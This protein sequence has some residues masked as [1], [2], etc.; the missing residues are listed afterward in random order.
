MSVIAQQPRNPAP[1]GPG[2]PRAA[3]AAPGVQRVRLRVQ[4]TVQGVGFRPF[5]HTLAGACGLGG[6]VYNDAEGVRIELEGAPVALAAFQTRLRAEL[7]PLARIEALHGEEMAPLGERAFRIEASRGALQRFTLIS[8]DVATCPTCLEELRTAGNRR[9]RHPF[10]NC[11]HCGPRFTLIRDIPYDRVNTTMAAFPLCPDCEGEYRDPADRRFHAEPTACPHCGPQLRLLDAAGRALAG[12]PLAGAV[13]RLRAGGIVAVKGIGGFHLAC[14]ARDAAAVAELRR[15]KQRDDKPFAVMVADLA[16]ARRLCL[17]DERAAALL[18]APA[19]PIVLLPRRADAD[20]AEAVAPGFRE[21]G[22]LLP[23]T[24]LHHLLLGDSG[25]ALVMTSGNRSDEPIAYRDEEALARLAPLVDAFLLHDRAI[26]VRCDDSVLR[27]GPAAPQLLRRSRGY[28]P[29]PLRLQRAFAR[30]LLA[31]GG[32]LKNTF[33]LVRDRFAFIS[34]HIGD[35]DN[36]ETYASFVAGIEHFRRLFQIEP[37][38]IV[39]DLHPDYLSTRYALERAGEAERVGVQHHHAHVASA[40]ADNDLEGPVIGVAFD[41][42]GYGTDGRLWGGEFLI[43]DYAGFQRAAHWSYFPLPGG[44]QAIREPWRVAQA[45][46]GQAFG[47]EAEGLLPRLLPAIAPAQTR[48]LTQMIQR[49]FNT[50]LSS[51]VGRLFDAAAAL[52]TGRTRVTFEGQAAIELEQRAEPRV[53]D[54]FALELGGPPADGQPWPLPS[55]ALLGALARGLLDGQAPGVLAA[56]F[57]NTLAEAVGEVCAQLSARHG[58]RRVVLSGGVF[59]NSLL[60]G[61]ALAALERRGLQVF[62]QRRVPANDGGLA[63]GQAMIGGTL[64]CA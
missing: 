62:T 53:S 46:L 38:V 9:H 42:T 5:V 8:P 57:H 49:G 18:E 54:G 47:A 56:R 26:H 29:A 63:L 55:A 7:P 11:T 1:G 3:P 33:C 61:R 27:P 43:A 25:L 60:L 41:G 51:G 50:P 23:Y 44:A 24:P 21:L 40:M 37:E 30:P 15:R 64:R 17:V 12:E 31:C 4:G 13:A 22:L 35:L 58:L 10:I 39:H 16:Q 32:E 14:A 36:E 34:P 19:R 6:F 2:L 48:V 20:V 59:Q 45:L 28:V 52:L